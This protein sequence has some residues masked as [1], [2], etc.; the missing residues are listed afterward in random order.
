M[1]GIAGV[2]ARSDAPRARCAE[3]ARTCAQ[4]LNHRGPDGEGLWADEPAGVALA[5]RRLAIIDL[6]DAG[7]QPIR[8]PQRLR[9]TLDVLGKV[10]LVWHL[11]LAGKRESADS[12]MI[13]MIQSD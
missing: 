12:P 6:S 3:L 9:R 5:H 11:S 7:A 4:L 13:F 10:M 1:C 2:V 8:V